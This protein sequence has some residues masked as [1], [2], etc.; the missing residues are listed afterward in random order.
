[1]LQNKYTM[2]RKRTIRAILGLTQIEI[3]MILNISR[4]QWS[5]Y[6]LNLRNLPSAPSMLLFEVMAYME[7]NQNIVIQ[8]VQF[9][10]TNDA[11]TKLL[12]EKN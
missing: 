12:L 6:E 10:N 1:M 5:L 11:K 7:N 4:S 3:A 2:K 8:E 9:P